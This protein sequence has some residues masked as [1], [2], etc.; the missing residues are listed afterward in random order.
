MGG[1][2]RTRRRPRR[3]RRGP[4]VRRRLTTHHPTPSA[5]LKN[6]FYERVRTETSQVPEPEQLLR[7]TVARLKQ[8][9]A[10]QN[11]E[12]RELRQ[13]ITRL[14]LAAAVLTHDRHAQ[15]C[16]DL[17]NVVLLPRR[18]DGPG[19]PESDPGPSAG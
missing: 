9:V 1:P 10:D 17:G 12:I 16:A 11:A 7:K 19:A 6:E 3:L 5:D 14:T 18:P 4:P 13:Q 15:P 8:A 2:P